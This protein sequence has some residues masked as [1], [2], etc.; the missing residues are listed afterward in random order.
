MGRRHTGRQV[1]GSTCHSC[2]PL[3][4]GP[5]LYQGEGSDYFCDYC[6]V[7][8][9]GTFNAAET[10]KLFCKFWNTEIQRL[11]FHNC[12]SRFLKSWPIA[13][14]KQKR[15]GGCGVC[16][17]ICLFMRNNRIGLNTGG[18]KWLTRVTEP[19]TQR[20]I[21]RWSQCKQIVGAHSSRQEEVSS[22]K[23]GSLWEGRNY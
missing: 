11:T 1:W 13:F 3:S 23:S 8:K 17:S 5:V 16:N 9:S 22:K 7:W 10:I 14:I 12:I 4:S 21:S 15:R 19:V 2:S 6:R 20:S 18:F